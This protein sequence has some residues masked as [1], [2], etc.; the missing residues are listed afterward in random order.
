MNAIVTSVL[1]L[2][3]GACA[4]GLL[5]GY[6]TKRPPGQKGIKGTVLSHDPKLFILQM[7][8][9]LA[10]MVICLIGATWVAL[11]H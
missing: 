7:G 2:T 1:V 4:F 3:A 11:Q 9:L 5:K 8:L 10:L 6:K